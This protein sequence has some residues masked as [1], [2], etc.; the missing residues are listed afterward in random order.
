MLN[1]TEPGAWM[2]G[3]KLYRG[4]GPTPQRMETRIEK[5][6]KGMEMPKGMAMP[7][8]GI[9]GPRWTSILNKWN[10]LVVQE[11]ER[12]GALHET[13]GEWGSFGKE[14]EERNGEGWTREEGARER[15]TKE[16]RTK[17]EA[18]MKHNV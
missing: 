10:G 6:S 16:Q 2:M 15:G 5:M 8:P 4:R 12:V 13:F 11:F 7:R 17:D 18:E 14:V 1:A 3:L 9:Q